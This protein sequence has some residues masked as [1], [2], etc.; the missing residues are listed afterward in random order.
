MSHPK[1]F[2]VGP[3]TVSV[4]V[5]QFET[6]LGVEPPNNW[7]FSAKPCDVYVYQLSARLC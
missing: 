2:S 6:R 4:D 5:G 7:M 3:L 1:V